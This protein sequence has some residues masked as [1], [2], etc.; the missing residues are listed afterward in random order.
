VAVW[1]LLLRFF[2]AGMLD[3]FLGLLSCVSF[4]LTARDLRRIYV[5]D[6]RQPWLYVRLTSFALVTFAPLFLPAPWSRGVVLAGAV[7]VVLATVL[8][9]RS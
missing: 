8:I 9:K 7:V 4:G 3:F 2:P 1:R 6:D 5:E